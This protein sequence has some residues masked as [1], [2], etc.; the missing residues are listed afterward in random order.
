MLLG[1]HL[2]MIKK[3]EQKVKHKSGT[4]VQQMSLFLKLVK[5]HQKVKN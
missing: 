3:K 2:E 5:F 1:V 4:V